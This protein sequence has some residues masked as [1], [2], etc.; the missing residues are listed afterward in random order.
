MDAAP[1]LPPCDLKII[2][3]MK[4]KGVTA[5]GASV[6]TTGATQGSGSIKCTLVSPTKVV[7]KTAVGNAGVSGASVSAEDGAFEGLVKALTSEFDTLCYI[8]HQS[9]RLI[10]DCPA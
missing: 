2:S 6:S 4:Q 1:T 8:G 7:K 3:K 9:E 10:E 5:G